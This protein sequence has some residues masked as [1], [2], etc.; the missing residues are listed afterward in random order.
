M[1]DEEKNLI[2]NLFYRL[3]QTELNSSERDISADNLIQNLVSKQPASSY[4][5]TQTILIQETAIKKMSNKIEELEKKIHKFNVE[6]SNK[7]PSFLSSFFKT[8][9]NFKPQS[10]SNDNNIWRNKE[11]ISQSN[12]ANS[13]IPNSPMS[14]SLP[15]VNHYPTGN[16]RSNGFLSSALQTATGVAGGMILGNMLMNVFNHSKPEEEIF[17]TVHSSYTSISDNHIEENFFDKN[18]NN[19]LINY[20][21]NDINSNKY[22]SNS[23]DFDNNATDDFDANDD[24][25]I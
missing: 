15:V 2:E 6:E 3:K 23:E 16:N 22:E 12:Y 24:N 5:M 21:H 8:N 25:F 7:K 1:K 11:N 18:E 9:P 17:D 20:K 13:S 19:D 4:Y 14:Q 10:T